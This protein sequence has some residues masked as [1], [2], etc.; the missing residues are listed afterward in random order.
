MSYPIILCEDKLIQLQQ[1]DNIIQNYIIFHNDRLKVVLKTQSPQEVKDYLERFKPQNGIYFLDIDLN[2]SIN[3][4]D[5]AEFIRKQDAQAKIVFITTHEELAPLT[6][7]RKV[8]ALGFVAKDQEFDS[9]RSEIMSLL[10]LARK[11]IVAVKEARN[12]IFTFSVGNQIYNFDM[13]EILFV[14][15]SDI[16]HRVVLYTKQGQYEFYGR[17]NELEDKYSTLFRASRGCLVNLKN[18][19]EIDFNKRL[20]VFEEDLSRNFSLGRAKKIKYFIKE[21]NELFE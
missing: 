1:L 6:L 5:L 2:H 9:F 21:K 15:P 14:E 8:E 10:E 17:L 19:K 12:I 3:G 20:L 11:R 18:A 4:I 13:D 7:K 16:P